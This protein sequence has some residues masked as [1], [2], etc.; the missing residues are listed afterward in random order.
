VFF[1]AKEWNDAVKVLNGMAGLS[2]TIIKEKFS[3]KLSFL[4][5][6]GVEFNEVMI[7]TNDGSKSLK[8]IIGGFI[9]ILVFKNSMD[10]LKSF[11]PNLFNSLFITTIFIMSILM[12]SRKS[13]FLY[14]NF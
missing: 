11:K 3:D 2:G 4:L 9:L 14:F 6:Y 8:W 10:K 5:E 13:E 7:M 12:L 1:R